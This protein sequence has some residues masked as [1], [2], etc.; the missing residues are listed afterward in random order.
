MIK[1]DYS[2]TT[3]LFLTYPKGFCDDYN[4][5][6]NFYQKLIEVIPDKIHQYLI[7]NN[8]EAEVELKSLYPNKNITSVLIEG[9]NEIWLRDIMGFNVGDKIIKPIYQ[10]TY[11]KDVYDKDYLKEIDLQVREIINK[12]IQKEII[13]LPLIWDGGNL[14]TNGKIGFITDKIL[15][16]NPERTEDTIKSIIKENLGI[17]P[18]IIPTSKNDV[19]GHSDGYLAFIDDNK[20]CLSHYPYMKTLEEDIKYLKLL[21]AKLLELGLEIIKIYDRP[22]IERTRK[23]DDFLN[24]ARGCYINF[25]NLGD[26]LI[27]PEFTLTTPKETLFYNIVNKEVFSPYNKKVAA[28]NCDALSKMGGVLHCISFI[29]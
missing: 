18:I 23:G 6:T 12:T 16:D 20:I 21:E 2:K 26:E 7:V 4:S 8:K 15:R 9:F 5:L 29:N 28:I 22:I 3:D 27:T 17:E 14:V 19:L 10:P 24:S 13:D 25:I 11:Y 1:T